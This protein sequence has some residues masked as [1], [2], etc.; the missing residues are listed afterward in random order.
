MQAESQLLVHFKLRFFEPSVNLFIY[1][2][3]I[4]S[5]VIWAAVLRT[6]FQLEHLS[7]VSIF[8]CCIS[9]ALQIRWSGGSRGG[10]RRRRPPTYTYFNHSHLCSRSLTL[11]SLEMS[12]ILC[13]V[14]LKCLMAMICIAP[15]AIWIISKKYYETQEKQRRQNETYKIAAITTIII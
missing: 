3:M 6:Q 4:L 8:A 13:T 2:Y 14:S 12:T 10:R 15:I 11:Q 9:I 5:L 1:H 7:Q